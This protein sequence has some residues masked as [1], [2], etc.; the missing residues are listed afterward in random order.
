MSRKRASVSIQCGT[1]PDIQT[2][3]L[4]YWAA[5][6]CKTIPRMIEELKITKDRNLELPNITAEILQTVLIF[7]E[8]D[9]CELH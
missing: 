7:L 1:G 8:H 4:P 3:T 2:V 9:K 5:S 6:K